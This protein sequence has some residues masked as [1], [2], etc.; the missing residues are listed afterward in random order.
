MGSKTLLQHNPPVLNWGCR[1]KEVT[2]CVRCSTSFVIVDVQCTSDVVWWPSGLVSQRYMNST[3]WRLVC[4]HAGLFSASQWSSTHGS[5]KA[6]MPSSTRL[7]SGAFS[8]V[9][10][11]LL[12]ILWVINYIPYSVLSQ[13]VF[14][15]CSDGLYKKCFPGVCDHGFW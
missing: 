13:S 15:E 14:D 10:G 6:G 1:Q 2:C 3:P 9:S 8:Y 5:L 12:Y 11:S 4:M 7:L